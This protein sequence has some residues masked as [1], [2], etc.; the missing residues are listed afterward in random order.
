VFLDQDPTSKDRRAIYG[1]P[2]RFRKQK[3]GAEYRSLSNFWLVHPEIAETIYDLTAIAVNVVEQ[4]IDNQY[5]TIDFK[6]LGD[7][8]NWLVPGFKPSSCHHPH[9][10][11][12]LLKSAIKEQN[13]E[14]ALPFL[15]LIKPHLTN[16]LF[17]LILNPK[18]YSSDLEENWK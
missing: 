4:E 12:D 14:K 9:Y 17:E 16:E 6:S 13:K 11:L 8:K 2:G 15:E 7:H 5:W 18:E 3:H 1:E 10:D